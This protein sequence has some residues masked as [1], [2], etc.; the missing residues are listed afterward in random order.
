MTD[1]MAGTDTL[2]KV[3]PVR[4]HTSED[5]SRVIG[6]ATEERVRAYAAQSDAVIANRMREVEPEWDIE[7]VLEVNV[8]TLAFTGVV[9][10]GTVDKR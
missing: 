6:R 8:A 9:L 3:D 4:R 7:R 5:A 2:T 10:G 1:D